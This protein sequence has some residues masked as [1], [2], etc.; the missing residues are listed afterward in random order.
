MTT[1]VTQTSFRSP[2]GAAVWAAVCSS[3]LFLALVAILHLVRADL[4]PRSHVLS[5]YALGSAGWL[6]ALAF[7]AL[8]GAFAALAVALWNDL[9][10]WRGRIG[11]IALVLAAVGSVMGGL[12]P[13]DPVGTPMDK[14][15]T[16]AQLHGLSFMLGGPGAMLAITFVNWQLGRLAHWKSA[17]LMLW[18]TALFAWL[19]DG[20]FTYAMVTVMGNPQGDDM[21]LGLWNRL[22]VVSWVLWIILVARRARVRE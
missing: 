11:Q 15:S 14:Q 20:M 8:G 12:F 10:G 2:A 22:L 21:A 3:L 5:E 17:Q 7:F 6:M 4:V 9:T 16:T 18:G 19:V 1:T 13:M